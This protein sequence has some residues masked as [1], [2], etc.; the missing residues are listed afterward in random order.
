MTTE[1]PPPTAEDHEMQFEVRKKASKW[2]WGLRYVLNS[3]EKEIY[4][5]AYCT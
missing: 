2:T 3:Q 1:E 4:S 5:N